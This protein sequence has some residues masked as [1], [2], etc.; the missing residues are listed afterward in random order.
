MKISV[1]KDLR[2]LPDAVND[3]LPAVRMAGHAL[4]EGKRRVAQYLI[5]AMYIGGGRRAASLL[6]VI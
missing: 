1:T 6:Q 2:P 3:I 5:S 4:I